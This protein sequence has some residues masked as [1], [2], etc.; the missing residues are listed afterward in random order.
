MTMQIRNSMKKAGVLLCAAGL[1]AVFTGCDAASSGETY[2]PQSELPYGATLTKDIK[3]YS[4]PVQYDERFVPVEAVK[5]AL[6][7]YEAIH[8]VDAEKFSALQFPMWHDFYLS[9]TLGGEFTDAQILENTD[10]ELKEFV[11]SD[12]DFALIDITGCVENEGKETT[13]NVLAVLDKMAEEKGESKI[14]EDVGQ[15]Y[16]LTVTRYLTK[17]GSGKHGETD[18][19]L[20][21]ELLYVFSYKDQWYEEKQSMKRL[22][23]VLCAAVMMFSVTACGEQSSQN[24]IPD[25]ME[26]TAAENV[27]QEYADIAEAYFKAVQDDDYEAYV[28]LVYPPY[29]EIYNKYLTENKNTDTEKA[30]HKM[31]HVFDED[32]YESWRLTGLSLEARDSA[33]E[34]SFYSTYTEM[35]VLDDAFVEKAKKDAKEYRSIRFTTRSLSASCPGRS[36]S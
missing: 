34:E 17:K 29:L 4:M 23:P 31:A 10:K 33:D 6:S 1:L 18:L 9:E 27:P 14:S 5:T 30:F 16:E 15:F 20:K 25:H 7:Y 32:G 28:K 13:Q 19:A 21:D 11:G 2:I 26:V 8:N 3:S 24:V 22:L 35:G 36:C 12:Y